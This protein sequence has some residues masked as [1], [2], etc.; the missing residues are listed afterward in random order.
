MCDQQSTEEVYL[1]NGNDL[2]CLP[3]PV[4]LGPQHPH[5]Q[6]TVRFEQPPLA[7]CPY[8]ADTAIFERVVKVDSVVLGFISHAVEAHI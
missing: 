8:A 7:G 2:A 1:V 5:L 6:Q 3:E 4:A